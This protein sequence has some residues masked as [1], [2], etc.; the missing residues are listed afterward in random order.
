MP[1]LLLLAY[2]QETEY[3]RALL[4]LLSCWAWRPQQALAATICTDRPDF[5]RPYLAGLAVDFKLATP[6]YLTK[7]RGPQHYVHRVK[8]RFIAEAFAEYPTEELLFVDS[9]TFFIASP[10]RLF[11]DLA[12]GQCF[13]HLHEYTLADAVGIHAEF[14]QAKYPK[15][16]LDLLA[17]RRFQLGG[18]QVQF[19]AGQ[20]SWNS[21]VLGIPRALTPLLPDILVLTDER[22]V[23]VRAARLFAR[24][25][26]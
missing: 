1:R 13:M 26:G 10:N 11:Q 6:E 16:M 5:F 3:R 20:S 14:N 12:A 18:A 7:S 19:H 8:A 4:A 21:G 9:D 15:K 24:L 17:S 22:L 25:A 2:G 23:Y